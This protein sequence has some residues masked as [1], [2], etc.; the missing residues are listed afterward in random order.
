M[1][2]PEVHAHHALPGDH[3]TLRAHNL[4]EPVDLCCLCGLDH[5]LHE[6]TAVDVSLE[7][8]AREGP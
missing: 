3:R 1:R 7:D 4:C 2:L 8:L 5:D 6:V